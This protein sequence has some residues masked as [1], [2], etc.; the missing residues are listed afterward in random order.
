MKQEALKA[1]IRDRQSSL[2][3]FGQGNQPIPGTIP[4]TSKGNLHIGLHRDRFRSVQTLMWQMRRTLDVADETYSDANLLVKHFMSA[5]LFDC[6][7]T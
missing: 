7:L 2:L 6:A 3:Q 1:V 5:R 4:G